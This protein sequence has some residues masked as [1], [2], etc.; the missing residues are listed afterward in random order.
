[1][2]ESRQNSPEE[3]ASIRDPRVVP[4]P[5]DEG[6]EVVSTDYQHIGMVSEVQGNTLYVAPNTSLPQRTRRKLDWD[7]HRK[8]DHPISTQYIKEINEEVILT[9]ESMQEQQPDRDGN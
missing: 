8:R 3:D 2:N 5:I 6:K 7:A 9:V 4:G 1:M